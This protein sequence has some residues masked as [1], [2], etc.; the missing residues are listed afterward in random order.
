MTARAGH[1]APGLRREVLADGVYEAIKTLIMDRGIEPG[2]KINMES[3]SRDLDVSPTPVR[4]ALARL[5]SDGLVTKKP[6][7]GYTAAPLLDARGLDELF[8]LRLMLEP[9]AARWAAGG[10]TAPQV[11][12]LS[13]MLTDV[14]EFSGTASGD[15]YRGYR[16]VALHDGQFHDAI[17]EASGRVLLLQTLRKLHPH[18]QLY[19]LFFRHGLER[20]TLVEHT[21]ILRALRSGDP[22]AAA[23]AMTTHLERAYARFRTAVPED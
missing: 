12:E 13:R 6:L 21:E 18:A 1:E 22:N 19:R 11:G 14:R 7:V 16:E 8:E 2:A 9:V 3:L 15:D 10:I 20:E 23:A 5:E 17:A 4:E